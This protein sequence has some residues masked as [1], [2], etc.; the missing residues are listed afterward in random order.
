LEFRHIASGR[1]DYFL[2]PAM[3]FVP[4]QSIVYDTNK[5]GAQQISSKAKQILRLGDRSF[6]CQS[7]KLRIHMVSSHRSHRYLSSSPLSLH[8][9]IKPSHA[10]KLMVGM[11][12]ASIELLIF[13]KVVVKVVVIKVN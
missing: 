5:I 2:V 13:A 10:R 1:T 3:L 11:H 4:R 12:T 9:V 8:Q 7:W 6:L